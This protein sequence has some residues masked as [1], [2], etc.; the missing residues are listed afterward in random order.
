MIYQEICGI[1]LGSCLCNS[2]FGEFLGLSLVLLALIN[3]FVNLLGWA[4]VITY[5]GTRIGVI[6]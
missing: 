4:C 6:K 2:L 1:V 3:A 5:I